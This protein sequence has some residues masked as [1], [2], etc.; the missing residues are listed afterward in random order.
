MAASNVT[1][2]LAALA[3]AF[4]GSQSNTHSVYTQL[5][6][7][8]AMAGGGRPYFSSRSQMLRKLMGSLGSPCDCS[9]IGARSYG[10]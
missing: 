7:P 4:R 2:C 1:P 10:L 5:E 6:R 3:S 8:M 9:M